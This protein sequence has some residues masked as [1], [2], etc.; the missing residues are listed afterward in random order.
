MKLLITKVWNWWDVAILKWCCMLYGVAAGVYFHELLNQYIGI[1]L[2]AAVI[3]T[4][5]PAIAY[6]KD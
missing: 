4:I 1:I 5:R 3:L 2:V 6:W